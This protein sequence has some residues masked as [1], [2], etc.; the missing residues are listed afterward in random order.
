MRLLIAMAVAGLV[1]GA[2]SA[3]A[4]L[5][6]S[7]HVDATVDFSRYQSFD[8][9]PADALPTGD[10]R[11]DHN[12]FFQDRLQ[13]AVERGLAARGLERV[14]PGS[15]PDLLIHYH[16]SATQRIYANQ[17]DYA[18]G[19]TVDL[20]SQVHEYEAGIIVVDIVDRRTKA[21]IWRGWAQ[22]SLNDLVGDSPAMARRID[23]GVRRML[24]RLPAAF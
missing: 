3:C 5:Q 16:A 13:G 24:A 21:V 22:C 19:Y 8:W 23:E 20:D 6:V 2:H 9:G 15:A 18:Y 1:I 12:A 4:T 11:L 10:P 14:A 17:G 7:S